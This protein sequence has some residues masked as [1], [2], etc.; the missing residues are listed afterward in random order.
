MTRHHT[1]VT[2]ETGI[3]IDLIRVKERT[4]EPKVSISMAPSDPRV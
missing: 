1:V 2:P 3:I 4:D